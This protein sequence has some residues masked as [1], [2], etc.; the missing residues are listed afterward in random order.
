MIMKIAVLLAL[1]FRGAMSV[2]LYSRI[3]RSLQVTDEILGGI[4]KQWEVSRYPNFLRTCTMTEASWDNLRSKFEQRILA[5]ELN[6]SPKNFTVS[7]TGSSVTA[8]HDSDIQDSFPGLVGKIMQP[9][10]AEMNI[11][12]ISR[13]VAMGNNVWLG[14]IFNLKYYYS[15]SSSA[16]FTL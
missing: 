9:A 4:Y 5:A 14:S 7:F 1:L 10:L 16:L 11:E 15:C 3:K 8:G 12:F 13:N 2:S 6:H